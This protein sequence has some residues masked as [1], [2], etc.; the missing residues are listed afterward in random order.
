[1]GEIAIPSFAATQVGESSPSI[2]RVIGKQLFENADTVQP[3]LQSCRK[4]IIIGLRGIDSAGGSFA[5]NSNSISFVEIDVLERELVL[6]ET[7][8]KTPCGIFESFVIS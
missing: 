8:T 3:N 2:V 4:Q 7:M 1:M 6:E 5:Q